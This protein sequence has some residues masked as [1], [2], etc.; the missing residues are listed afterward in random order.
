MNATDSYFSLAVPLGRFLGTR[1]K[2]SALMLIAVLAVIWR[3]Q[4]LTTSLMFSV[5]MFLSVCL[6]EVTHVWMAQRMKLR[7]PDRI[8]WPFGG[9]YGQSV[10][11]TNPVVSLA[12]PC[13]CLILAFVA[14]SQLET[15]DEILLLL[16]PSTCWQGFHSDNMMIVLWRICFFVNVAIVAG[17][18]IP[19]RPMAMG[20]V[21]QSLLTR[22]YSRLESRDFLL[23]SG[24]VLSIFGLLAGFVFDLSV[25]TALS[26]FMLL[27]HAQEAVAWLQPAESERDF[28][29]FDFSD[30]YAEAGREDDD[31]EEDDIPGS[32]IDRW[33]NRRESERDLRERE[34]EQREHDELDRV[35]EKLHTQGRDALSIAE[36]HLLNRVSAKLR[37]KNP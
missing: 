34:L 10:Q 35:L 31:D 5:V 11:T 17:N 18:L 32:V 29:D 28:D 20:Y 15:R 7:C 21:L 12:G 14:G 30:R 33:K 22:R 13:L 3:V 19:V 27:L 37:Q 24:L 23:R 1:F 16:N 25:L 9:F 6:H 4:N 36:L 26:A 8:L 2:L